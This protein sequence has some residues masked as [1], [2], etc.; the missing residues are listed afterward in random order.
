[1]SRSGIDIVIPTTSKPIQSILFCY[2]FTFCFRLHSDRSSSFLI[3]FFA[4]LK[5]RL[6]MIVPESRDKNVGRTD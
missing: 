6:R 4:F 2:L 1:M 5:D 3:G